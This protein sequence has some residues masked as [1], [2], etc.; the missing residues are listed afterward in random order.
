MKYVDRGGKEKQSL[1]K[2]YDVT[3]LILSIFDLAMID[4]IDNPISFFLNT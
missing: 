3:D 2:K 1:I 4:T